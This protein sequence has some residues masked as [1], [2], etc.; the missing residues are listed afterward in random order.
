MDLGRAELSVIEEERG[1]SGSLFFEGDSGR[2][3]RVGVA[4]LGGDGEGLD[5]AAAVY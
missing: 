1:L 2:L 3:G 5:L 4:G